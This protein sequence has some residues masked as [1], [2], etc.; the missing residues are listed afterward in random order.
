M[1][2]VG[3]VFHFENTKHIWLIRV[4]WNPCEMKFIN[5][6]ILIL[7]VSLP[8][9]RTPPQYGW[10]LWWVGCEPHWFLWIPWSGASC[11]S[12]KML[13]FGAIF[14]LVILIK[15]ILIK[16]KRCIQHCWRQSEFWSYKKE[17]DQFSTANSYLMHSVWASVCS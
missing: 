2:L 9:R 14:S 13:N 6:G 1:I 17:S 4:K 7:T 10:F 8:N 3:Y 15:R 5:N 11:H 12:Y 16:K